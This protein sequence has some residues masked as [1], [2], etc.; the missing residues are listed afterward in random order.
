[1]YW[2][3]QMV[4]FLLLCNWRNCYYIVTKRCILSMYRC[5]RPGP[6]VQKYMNDII[7]SYSND[8]HMLEQ[9]Y[10]IVWNNFLNVKKLKIATIFAQHSRKFYKERVLTIGG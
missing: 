9:H 10:V 6:N 3:N 7:G 5:L 8:T 2:T 1:M 4:E